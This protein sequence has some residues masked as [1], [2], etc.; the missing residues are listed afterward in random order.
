MSSTTYADSRTA[1]PVFGGDAAAT[2]YRSTHAMTTNFA[3]AAW[4][5]F[6]IGDTFQRTVLDA[7][8]DLAVLRLDGAQR[9]GEAVMDQA[10]EL[11][12]FLPFQ[13][14]RRHPISELQANYSVFKLVQDGPASVSHRSG[15]SF[16]VVD[17]IETAYRKFDY[18][19]LW[20]IEGIGHDYAEFKWRGANRAPSGL[21]DDPSLPAKSLTMMHAGLGLFLAMEKM[22]GLTPNCDSEQMRTSIGAFVDQVNANSKAGY[23]GAAIESLGLVTRTW[24]P[25]MVPKVVA[26]MPAG[27]RGYFWHGAG[28]AMYFLP[29]YA[30]PGILSPWAALAREKL[31][32]EAILNLEA[33]L[34]WATTLVNLQQPE[35]IE[36]LI[37]RR[38]A[39]FASDGGFRNGVES[40]LVM[41]SDM[42][43]GDPAFETLIRREPTAAIGDQWRRLV[44]EPATSAVRIQHARLA[45]AGQLERVFRYQSSWDT[46]ARNY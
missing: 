33:G 11:A 44:R 10:V 30:L 29:V 19:V 27:L 24:F 45:A 8:F 7:M 35:I 16:P 13:S 21:L 14:P 26:A 9:L 38:G 34:T 25:E 42:A 1:A 28:R 2:L 20:V 23:A 46:A 43:P 37:A 3:G 18:H 39:A 36:N 15:S 4:A 41:A 22:R 12:S 6:Q 17:I 40:A 31:D 5:A 32:A